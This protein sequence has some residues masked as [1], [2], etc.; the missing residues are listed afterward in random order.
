MGLGKALV[1]LGGTA[2]TAGTIWWW[3]SQQEPKP[4]P[5]P[6]YHY[7]CIK[8][9]DTGLIV[10][11]LLE[12]AGTDTCDP[13]KPP[14]QCWSEIPCDSDDECGYGAKC[15]ENRCYWTANE[16]LD[17][18]HD[19]V[20][21]WVFFEFDERVVGN[22]LMGGNVTFKN[23]WGNQGCSPK[24]GIHLVRDDV[25]VKKIFEKEYPLMLMG[26][27]KMYPLEAVFFDAEAV[28]GILFWCKCHGILPFPADCLI[29]IHSQLVY[30]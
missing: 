8:D 6:P 16:L 29:K 25:A 13:Y 15:W 4:P 19:V 18:E 1:V 14:D 27:S 21:N 26:E 11:A 17:W 9:P 30:L 23:P 5:P 20:H 24:L 7:E 28:D 12:G 22:K 10:C 2:I 3:L